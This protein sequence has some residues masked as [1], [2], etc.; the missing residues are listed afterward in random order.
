MCMQR[1]RQSCINAHTEGKADVWIQTSSGRSEST[2]DSTLKTKLTQVI[3]LAQHKEYLVPKQGV[4]APQL[5]WYKPMM[6]PVLVHCNYT[7]KHLLEMLL[8][9][10]EHVQ[11]S[12]SACTII[13]HVS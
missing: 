9:F 8:Y 11:W 10:T 7:V 1:G 13:K 2:Q 5:M 3:K 4:P 12:R 6:L